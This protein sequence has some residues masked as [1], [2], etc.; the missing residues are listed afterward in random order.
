MLPIVWLIITSFSD[1]MGPSASFIPKKW[2]FNN[3]VRL[4]TDDSFP[5]WRWFLNTLF[6]AIVSCVIS[7]LF[8]F[9]TSY[10]LSR[11]RFKWRKK[12]LNIGLILG[13]F[14]GFMSMAA[15]YAIIEWIGLSQSLFALILVYCA[16][17]AMGYQI[18][19]GFFDTIHIHLMRLLLLMV[20]IKT[21]SSGE[22][23]LPLSKPILVYTALTTFTALGLTLYSSAI[24]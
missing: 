7:T 23:F 18:S 14:P 17:A 1:Q 12:F 6:V 13:M 8:V 2:T 11:L 16:G 10:T 24:S 22:L 19:K 15:I 3:Y 5:Y 9:M 20:L 21:P 4:I